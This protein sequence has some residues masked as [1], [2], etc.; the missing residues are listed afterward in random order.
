[1]RRPSIGFVGAAV[2][3]CAAAL[4][5][6]AVAADTFSGRC[7]GQEGWASWP[8]QPMTVVPVD[9]LLVARLGGGACSG[10]LNGREI[11]SAPATARAILRGVQSCGAATT[12]GRFAFRVAGRRFTG[13]MTYFRTGSRIT[14]RWEGDAGGAA[15]VLVRAQVGLV[16]RDD[17]LAQTPV[18]GPLVSAPVSTEETLRRCA[19]E[20]LSR[21]PILA[22]QIVTLGSLSG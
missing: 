13:R 11:E 1:M 18:A 3:A 12:S 19:A 7:G 20:G 9:M 21:M 22:D 8:E 5:A 6:P 2:A 14:A 4:P 16:R 17:P 15:L 10:T